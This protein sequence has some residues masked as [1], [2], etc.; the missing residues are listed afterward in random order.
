MTAYISR[1]LILCILCILSSQSAISQHGQMVIQ[2]HDTM[3]IIPLKN[4]RAANVVHA[5]YEQCRDEA[6]GLTM[7][8]RSQAEVIRLQTEIIRIYRTADSLNIDRETACCKEV[9]TL[10]K[11]AKRQGADIIYHKGLIL[12]LVLAIL[13]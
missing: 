4:I 9:R 10:E 5:M 7:A 6:A 8:S 12:L 3:A 13:F 2:G 11:K 1:A